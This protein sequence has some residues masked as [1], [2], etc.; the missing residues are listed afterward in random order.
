MEDILAT[1]VI[2][3]PI[4]LATVACVAMG[5]VVTTREA[6]GR[7]RGLR[8][9]QERTHEDTEAA[10]TDAKEQA[11]R[12]LIRCRRLIDCHVDAVL[13]AMRDC[14]TRPVPWPGRVLESVC[15]SA[16]DW[17]S[18]L[19]ACTGLEPKEVERLLNS[20]LPITANLARQLEVFT[21]TPARY[22]EQ[23]W[24]AHDDYRTEAED[25]F[26]VEL[27]PPVTRRERS[28]PAG[29]SPASP[30]PIGPPSLSLA[31]TLPSQMPLA[32]HAGQPG[33]SEPLVDRGPTHRA[34]DVPPPVVP[35]P[36]LAFRSPRVRLPPPPRPRFSSPL[37]SRETP[38]SDREQRAG[39]LTSFPI[40]QDGATTLSTA[41][42]DDLERSTLN[43]TLPG[44]GS[45]DGA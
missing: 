31:A 37:P 13:T 35:S 45:R 6:L 23:V 39:M 33:G 19:G 1:M 32:V 14:R 12:E 18:K 38:E 20:D 25:S 7:E 11:E 29:A 3:S 40:R 9:A 43:T 28:G 5:F 8:E 4:G 16:P 30:A 34:L 15:A 2:V 26:V 27:G 41:D 44:I 21:G 22:W 36:E 10:L 42:W 17:R 24:R